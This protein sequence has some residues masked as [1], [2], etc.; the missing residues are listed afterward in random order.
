[1]AKLGKKKI[2]RKR[3]PSNKK[4]V[5]NV[6]MCNKFTVD[7]KVS[8]WECT[9]IYNMGNDMEICSPLKSYT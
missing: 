6:W 9:K 1:M 7:E 4:Y 3:S 5:E 8:H 2:W